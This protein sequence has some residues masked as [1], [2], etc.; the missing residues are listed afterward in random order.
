MKLSHFFFFHL[1][2]ELYAYVIRGFGKRLIFQFKV[3]NYSRRTEIFSSCFS[4]DDSEM[5]YL[6]SPS[7]KILVGHGHCPT[8]SRNCPTQGGNHQTLC[9]TSVKLRS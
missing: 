1:I 7:L 3:G 6:E 2:I 9:P 8:H 4:E 5:K